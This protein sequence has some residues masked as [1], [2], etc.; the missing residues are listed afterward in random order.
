[1]FIYFYLFLFGLFIGS[2]LN[3]LSDRLP[4][5]ETI[6]GRS[7][8]EFCKHQLSWK[9]LIPVVSFLYLKGHCRYCKKKFSSAY[10]I[11]ELFTAV[12]FILTWYLYTTYVSQNLLLGLVYVLI[13][14]CLIVILLS[15]IKY[16]IIPDEINIALILL[17]LVKIIL[18]GTTIPLFFLHILQSFIVVLPLLLIFIATKG[19]GMGF[20][21]VKFSFIIGLLVGWFQGLVT[22]YIAFI[23]GAIIG[24]IL[25]IKRKAKM[26][27]RMAF[28]PFLVIGLYVMLFF[29]EEILKWIKMIYRLE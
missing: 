20:G 27:S 23:G 25:L 9:D 12:M 10:P 26:K 4:R 29:S 24:I 22:L 17:G 15:D 6:M 14:A 13:T 11:S 2:F 8:C 16:H 3:V 28:G 1:M 7:Y 5:D 21:D 19:R 18:V